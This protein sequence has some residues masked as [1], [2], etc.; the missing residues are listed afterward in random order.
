MVLTLL[1]QFESAHHAYDGA[2]CLQYV[3]ITINAPS[4]NVASVD[5]PPMH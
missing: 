2:P 3:Q 1:G 5:V 4:V